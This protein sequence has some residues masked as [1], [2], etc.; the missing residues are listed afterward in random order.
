MLHRGW[1]VAVLMLLW[2]D[3]GHYYEY[4]HIRG[5]WAL[6]FPSR[7]QILHFSRVFEKDPSLGGGSVGATIVKIQA[8]YLHPPRKRLLGLDRG[9]S[10]CAHPREGRHTFKV[11]DTHHGPCTIEIG[12]DVSPASSGE[13]PEANGANSKLRFRHAFVP[14]IPRL[15]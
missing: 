3:V 1:L 13:D 11:D 14:S 5:G 2:E 4:F 12:T 7:T 10:A 9:S 6:T 15:V 8:L